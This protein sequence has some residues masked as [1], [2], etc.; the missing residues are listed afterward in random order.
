VITSVTILAALVGVGLYRKL[1]RGTPIRS[2]LRERT[3][4]KNAGSRG[5][6][7][8][9]LA[10]RRY[11]DDLFSPLSEG[12]TAPAAENGKNQARGCNWA[13]PTSPQRRP[14]SS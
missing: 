6:D 5:P 14:G 9:D 7:G 4:T 8:Q 2:N 10:K 12:R 11:G 3:A 1:R 13:H